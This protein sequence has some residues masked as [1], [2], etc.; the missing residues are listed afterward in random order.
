[1]CDAS[2]RSAS[3]TRQDSGASPVKS[4]FLIFTLAFSCLLVGG[5]SDARGGPRF[6]FDRGNIA[7]LEHDGSL[8]D[9]LTPEGTPNF[10]PRMRVTREFIRTHGDFYDFIIIF[11]SF[12]F[13]RDGADGFYTGVRND[14]QGIGEEVFDFGEEF[15]SGSRL[16]GVIDMGPVSNYG[17]ERL[18]ADPEDPRFL[19]TM[20]LLAHEMGHRWLAQVR[21]RDAY[22]E[23]SRDLLGYD[24]NHWSYLLSSDASFFYGNRWEDNGDGTFT[25]VEVRRQYSALDLYLIGLADAREV[26]PFILLRSSESDPDDLPQVGARIHARSETVRIEQIVDIEGPRIPGV[27]AA[28]R[29][30]NLA[31]ILLVQ[32]ESHRLPEELASIEAI[33]T[34]FTE[35][36]FT[37]TSG[38]ANV[39]TELLPVA[40]S[41]A[42]ISDILRWR[43]WTLAQQPDGDKKP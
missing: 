40:P 41:C 12:E 16:Q 38:R 20:A 14:T 5:R 23:A 9:K 31:F 11:T 29:E 35:S 24:G 22:G 36:F 32:E 15:G 10:E 19:T 8:Y 30:F 18:S 13:S 25:S 43:P 21:F 39:D 1:M 27:D 33:R 42:G 2:T 28:Q 4:K 34:G 7:V 37:L 26:S 17:Q 3:V 6:L